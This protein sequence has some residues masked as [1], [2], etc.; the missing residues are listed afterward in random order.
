MKKIALLI[1]IVLVLTSCNFDGYET[2]NST[3]SSKTTEEKTSESSTNETTVP[4]T[5]ETT[6]FLSTESSTTNSTEINSDVLIGSDLYDSFWAETSKIS[7]KLEFYNDSLKF[8]SSYGAETNSPQ[9]EVYFPANLTITLNDTKYYY[10]EVGV[11]TKGNVFSRSELFS[12]GKLNGSEIHFKINVSETFSDAT[13]YKGELQKFYHSWTDEAKLA[14]RDSR[15]LAGMGKIDIKYNRSNDPTFLRQAFGFKLYRDYGILAPNIALA[16]TTVIHNGSDIAIHDTYQILESIDK[17]FLKKRLG[18]DASK[19][20]LYKLGWTNVGSDFSTDGTIKLDSNGNYVADYKIGVEDKLNNK[21]YPYDLKTNETSS[22][23]QSLVNLIKVINEDATKVTPSNLGD[24]LNLENFAT[25][26]A[27]AYIVGSPDDLRN[28]YNN[29]YLYFNNVDNK[30]YFIP[31]DIDQSFGYTAKDM[32]SF[33]PT[34]NKKHGYSSNDSNSYI[35]M[36]LYWKTLLVSDGGS[37]GN[38]YASRFPSS[39]VSKAKYK[40]ILYNIKDSGKLTLNYFNNY[41]NQFPL[42]IGK[43]SQNDSFTDIDTYFKAK[44]NQITSDTRLA[45]Y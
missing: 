16:D 1:P 12:D 39:A 10:N 14:E 44:I 8:L 18:K 22:T 35:T 2:L 23:H 20:D 34:T 38:N 7:L 26:E 28:N 4:S 32:T 42:C 13:M 5:E 30:A 33:W 27:I 9:A 24:Y 11:R 43:N 31:Y 3:G 19:G 45:S 17:K 21:Y 41:I 40:E 29:T 6:S 25:V 37:E 36:A 15:T